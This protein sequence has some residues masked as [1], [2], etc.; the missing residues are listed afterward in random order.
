MFA[1]VIQ[2]INEDYHRPIIFIEN[3]YPDSDHIEDVAKTTYLRGHLA[4]VLKAIQNGV[5]IRGYIIWS[6]LDSFDWRHGYQ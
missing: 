6:L 5:D 4:E 3:G 1:K 2:H